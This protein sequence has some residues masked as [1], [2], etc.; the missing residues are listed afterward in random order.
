MAWRARV[1]TEAVPAAKAPAKP[2]PQA[3]APKPKKSGL[4]YKEQKELEAL[5]GRIA[6]LE[7]EQAEIAGK[8][9]DPAVYADHVRSAELHGRAAA[10]EEN[11]LELLTRWEELEAKAAG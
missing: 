9:A 1:P 10:I 6:D 2:A 8:M 7:R 11:L 3:A 4:G 5:P